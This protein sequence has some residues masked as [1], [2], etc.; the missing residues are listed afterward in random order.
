MT[1]KSCCN[2]R[3]QGPSERY[4]TAYLLS[5]VERWFRSVEFR[6]EQIM[7]KFPGSPVYILRSQYSSTPNISKT[8]QYQR[9]TEGRRNR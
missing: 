3:S 4:L 9:V 6:D 8:T 5:A 1:I 2:D 7:Y